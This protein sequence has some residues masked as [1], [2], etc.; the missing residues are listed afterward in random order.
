L[1]ATGDGTPIGGKQHPGDLS[2]GLSERDDDRLTTSCAIEPE[3]LIARGHPRAHLVYGLSD[4]EVLVGRSDGSGIA[5]LSESGEIARVETWPMPVRA[6]I[7]YGAHGRLAWHFP[8]VGRLLHRD[9]LSGRVDVVELPVSVYDAL[10]RPDG[11]VCLATDGGLWMWRPGGTAQPLVR[12]PWLVSLHAHGN[13]VR[14]CVRPERDD[15][16]R[17]DA[18]TEVLEW[19]AGDFAFRAVPVPAGTAPFAVAEHA[20]W[21]AEAWLD[22]CVVRLVR[23]DGRVFWLGCSG[24][25][26]LAW[27]GAS[28]YVATA[29]G[30]VLRF[31]NVGTRLG[32]D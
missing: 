5:V 20:G 26:S 15:Q 2:L 32:A 29:A 10:E 16:G 30:E 12:G 4:R 9:L 23:P 14:A 19:Q 27:A 7:P 25:R 31:P 11:S 6:S 3:S 18:T 22:G 13:G 8:D 24:P 21:R 17:W 28:L 1:V